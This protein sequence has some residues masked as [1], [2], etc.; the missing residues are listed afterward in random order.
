MEKRFYCQNLPEQGIVLLDGPEAHHLAKV[1]RLPP[2]ET[3]E[4][5][6]GA[7]LVVTAEILTIGKRDVSL[8]VRHA[9]R[10]P[11][12]VSRLVIATAVPKG[13]RFDWLVE[14]ATEL[15]VAA[16]IPLRTAR[17]VVDPRDSKLDRLRQVMIE[18]C[19]QSRRTWGMEL[20]PVTD[21]EVL[22][23]QPRP[24]IVADPSGG[25]VCD[26]WQTMTAASTITVAIGPEGGWADEELA[27]ARTAGAT[28]MAL[29]D[30]ILR[31]ETA[32]VAVAAMQSFL[33][34]TTQTAGA[35]SKESQ[36]GG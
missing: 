8:S 28:I 24:L 19:K 3:I 34:G 29:G 35:S 5:F 13:D 20:A 14:K 26:V 33:S 6:D 25:P 12:P 2:G 36:T 16:L 4:L 1:M 11:P 22:L 10:T 9:V 17:S 15:G 30:T 27:Q 18:A 32:A 23:R 7:G 31:I 21:F